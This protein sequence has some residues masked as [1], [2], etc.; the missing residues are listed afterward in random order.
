MDELIGTID[1]HERGLICKYVYVNV[2]K[3]ASNCDNG[4]SSIKYW[5][6]CINF[7]FE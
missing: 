6:N 7:E 4:L 5:K 3:C 1:G 2:N